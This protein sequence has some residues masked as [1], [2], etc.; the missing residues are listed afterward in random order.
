MWSCD[1]ADPG[2][3]DRV[4]SGAKAKVAEDREIAKHRGNMRQ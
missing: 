3:K 2:D 4:A 1:I